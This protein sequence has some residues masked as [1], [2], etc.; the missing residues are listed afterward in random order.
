MQ[1]RKNDIEEKR[2]KLAE[3]KARREMRATPSG[4]MSMS[5]SGDLVSPSPSRGNHRQEIESLIN[6]LVGE[7][8]PV[9]T[10]T[11]VGSPAPR[12]SRPNSVF[13]EG[14]LSGDHS[15]YASQANGQPATP[16]QPQFLT[17]TALNTVY[18]Y[19][20][21]P[22]REIVSYA[23]GTQTMDLSTQTQDDPSPWAL[24]RR[25]RAFSEI[26]DDDDVPVGATST[27]SKRLSRRE[28]DREEDLREKIRKEIEAE[29]KN[30]H[31]LLA[32]D[33]VP[34]E[35][36]ATS[37]FPAR[38]LTDE[39]LN[40]VTASEDFL[41]F[42]ERSTKVIERALDQEYDILRDYTLQDD[43]AD[44]AEDSGG[45]VAGKGRRRVKELVQFYDDRYSKK[46][47][48]SSIDFSPRFPEL[49]VASYTNNSTAPH[50]PDG[51]VQVWNMHL[52][53][54]PEFVFHAPS[55]I[56]TAKFSP[57]HPNLVVGGTYSGQVL[58]WDTRERTSPVQKT[59]LTGLGH[60]HPIYAVD[61]VGTPN[62]NNIISASTDGAVCVWAV[63][64]LAQPSENLMLTHP[65]PGSKF[66]DVA[67]TSMTF[68]HA[69][70][71]YFLVG[72]EEGAIYPCH[73]Y[74][75]AGAKAGIDVRHAY[76]GHAA[77]VMSVE[78]HPPTNA[79]AT[80]NLGDLVLSSSL[81]WSVKLWKVRAPA[82]TST[83]VDSSQNTS[84][85]TPLLDISRE[86]VVYDAAW[87]PNRPGVFALVDG[88]G[89]LEI[90]DLSVETEIPITRISPTERKDD[91]RKSLNK[92]AWERT[93][94]KRL[95]TGGINGA[96]TVFKVGADL[97]GKDG[98]RPDE[99]TSVDKLVKRLDEQA[100]GR[101][102]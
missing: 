60:S 34:G 24:P 21:E 51:I 54:R 3:L 61:V 69:D 101:V 81:D 100:N 30:T 87:S 13:S 94:G 96:V 59:P 20:P 22:V 63:D 90:W 33:F 67:P 97:G 38:A 37:N 73:R 98:I 68:P 55:D 23:K 6:S 57:F 84:G 32:D 52:H 58:L 85:I 66:D 70:P 39:E 95:A 11:G 72:T 93:D 75:R 99:W 15:E 5:G 62:A 12:G 82:A 1:K 53:D 17:T 91:W 71:T 29:L 8:R 48:V 7:S 49:L 89:W 2:R 80:S 14:Q 50:E 78:F 18:E 77:P 76:K 45:N 88:A 16:S 10:S 86:D 43:N 31:K 42:V 102:L 4:R 47:M 35:S 40:A 41:D 56:L 36:V 9:S 19:E 26:P 46:R 79:K 44:D 25:A 64:M 28:R 83:M 92:V 74:D 65:N 27:P